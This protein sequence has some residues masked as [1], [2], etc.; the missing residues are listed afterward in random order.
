MSCSDVR[1][2]FHLFALLFV[3]VLQTMKEYGWRE[4]SFWSLAPDCLT[5]L[6]AEII[7]DWLKHAFITRFNEVSAEVYKD[8]T[9]SLAYDLAQTKEKQAFRKAVHTWNPNDFFCNMLHRS[10]ICYVGYAGI[11][12]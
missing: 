6:G 9:I 2:R 8:Y 1:E 7:V 5:V 3:V 4:E 12:Y 10:Y 11:I